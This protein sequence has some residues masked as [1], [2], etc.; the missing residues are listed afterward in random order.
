[1]AMEVMTMPVEAPIEES[2]PI[3]DE[4]ELVAAI[5]G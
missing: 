3:V 4:P 2:P 1:M 5:A